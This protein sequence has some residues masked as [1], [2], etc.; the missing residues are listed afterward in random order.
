MTGREVQNK[1]R[2]MI[3]N[4]EIIVVRQP[5]GK[6]IFSGD[7][8]QPKATRDTFQTVMLMI[9]TGIIVYALK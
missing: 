9:L 5:S 8:G 3:G 7:L 6:Y 1:L 4:Q 2:E